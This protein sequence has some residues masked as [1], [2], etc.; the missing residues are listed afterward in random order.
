[1]KSIKLSSYF[2]LIKPTYQYI[3]IIPHKSIRNYNSSNIAKAIAH[4]Y[5]SIDRR[6]RKEKK[7]IFFECD[8]KISYM[9]DIN[10][11]SDKN[12]NAS[13]YFIVPKPFVNIILEK[14]KEIWNKATVKLIESGI[15]PFSDKAEVYQLSY[16]KEDALS[17]QVDKKSNEPLNSVLS[18][19][20]IMKDNDRI[21]VIYNF[22][23][24]SQ[25][26]WIDRYTETINKIK[27]KKVI[28]KKQT[29][30][31][32]IVKTALVYVI[33][34][35]NDLVQI[36]ND[37]T[38][39]DTNEDQE[40]IYKTIANVLEQQ[41]NLSPSTK[42]KKEQTILNTQIV[43]VSESNDDTRKSNN[44]LSVCQSY[45]SLDEDNELIYKQKHFKTPINIEDTDLGTE[46]NTF[47]TDEISNF[48]Q[49]PGRLLLT[50]FGINYIKTEEST[51]PKELCEGVKRLGSVKY[52]GKVQNA[53]L[54]NDYNNGNLPL[55]FIGSQGAGK[56]T[57][58]CHN[59]KDCIDNNEGVVVID[60]IK[61]CG[62]SESVKKITPKNKL[63]EIDLS[64]ENDLQGL[65]YNEIQI[66]EYMSA[67]QKCKLANLQSQQVM[68]LVDSIG[69]GEPLSSRMRRFLNA[70]SN[71]VFAL[72]YNSIKNVISCLENY[73]FRHQCIDKLTVELQELLKDEI[74]TVLELDEWSKETKD[75]PSEICG[76]RDS[77]I[78]YILDRVS[79]LRE[80]FKLK[81]MYNKK[82]NNNINLVDCMNKGKVV[83]IKMKED[84][85]PTKMSKNIMV[86][87]WIS[88]IWLACQ[89]RG[90]KEDQPLRCNVFIDEV[91]QA[92]TSLKTLEYVLPQTRKFGLK[93]I[94]STQYTEQLEDIFDTLVA[95]GASFMLLTGSTEKDFNYFKSKFD[96]FEY[97]DLK[98]MEEFS[99]MCL[100]KYS[101]GYASFISKLP[102]DKD[103]DNKIQSIA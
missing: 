5:K 21:S 3:Q 72:G 43:I 80:D 87:Y 85:F 15:E 102:Y 7:K 88:K 41:E 22:M 77:K 46:I 51:V 34:F 92:P 62:L 2:E 37:F 11:N 39:G 67:F 81:Y 103:L 79:M 50:Q 68:S 35:F 64:N 84:E 45:R 47:S 9:I 6:I 63:V 14:I 52:K 38:G 91:F 97:E 93:F 36:V 71:I 18:V 75:K 65:G 74:N 28:I 83:L 42:K 1:M 89:I 101:K 70:S 90:S 20:D 12:D 66:T 57:L 32:Y 86:T 33:K 78:E 58:I 17:L 98:D 40:S 31:E 25:F 82:L 19:I 16:K 60:F 10:K 13:F 44:A 56:T 29:S 26:G 49:I 23:P 24:C 4:T 73:K 59:V 94:F 48:I 69:V 96:K 95:S 61:N 27:D 54:E 8:F 99:A 55:L 53:Y 76:N 100:I 30:T